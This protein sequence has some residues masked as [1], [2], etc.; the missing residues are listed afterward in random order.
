MLYSSPYVRKYT[1]FFCTH[2]PPHPRSSR[3]HA[4]RSFGVLWVWSG[5]QPHPSRPLGLDLL[6][7][8]PHNL[9]YPRCF[10]SLRSS[11]EFSLSL[12]RHPSMYIL[13]ISRLTSSLIN[14]VTW[15][16][17]LIYTDSSTTTVWRSSHRSN[18]RSPTSSPSLKGQF[19]YHR[20]AFCS[21]IKSKVG[22]I[23][24]KD[25]GLRITLNIDGTPICD[26]WRRCSHVLCF[27]LISYYGIF[28]V[29]SWELIGKCDELTMRM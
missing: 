20:V 12:Y 1:Y 4:L 21:Q 22:N 17:H 5:L 15:S 8:H 6:Y 9:V 10:R 25:E 27:L 26:V 13:F 28:E 19:H 14:K 7:V 3:S 16:T 2:H 11:L 18:L 23:L 29:L 24:T